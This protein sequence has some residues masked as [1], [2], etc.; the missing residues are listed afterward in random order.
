MKEF[1]LELVLAILLLA[2][3]VAAGVYQGRGA[4]RSITV[5]ITALVVLGISNLLGILPHPG[6]DDFGRRHPGLQRTK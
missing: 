5:S 4:V 6:K 1:T 2:G 3:A